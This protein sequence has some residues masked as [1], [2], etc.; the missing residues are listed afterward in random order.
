MKLPMPT[1]QEITNIA[2][3]CETPLS[4]TN[5]TY[6]RRVIVENAIRLALSIVIDRMDIQI[7][8]PIGLDLSK[9]Q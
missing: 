9:P 4:N 3:Q 6:C 1:P 8:Q 2:N 7:P 5:S